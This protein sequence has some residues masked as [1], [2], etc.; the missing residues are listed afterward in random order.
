[1]IE[2]ILKEFEKQKLTKQEFADLLEW[3]G[4]AGWQ[5]VHAYL[6]G[7]NQPTPEVLQ[8]M[9]GVLGFKWKLVP[10]RRKRRSRK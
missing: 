3:D 2:A 10:K 9:A 7:E 4:R 1:M 8:E 5:R 6:S